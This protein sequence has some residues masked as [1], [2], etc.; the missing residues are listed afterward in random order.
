MIK[1]R[2]DMISLKH[3]C[4][5][6][7]EALAY[8]ISPKGADKEACIFRDV[9]KHLPS[10]LIQHLA[11]DWLSEKYRSESTDVVTLL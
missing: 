5:F 6:A 10:L 1:H 11:S 8:N 2:A 3:L 7:D 9:C 4:Q